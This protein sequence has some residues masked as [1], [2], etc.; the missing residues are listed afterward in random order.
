MLCELAAEVII[1]V[2]HDRNTFNIVCI[3]NI[4]HVWEQKRT[5]ERLAVR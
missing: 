2:M 3:M 1:P 5:D 4:Y